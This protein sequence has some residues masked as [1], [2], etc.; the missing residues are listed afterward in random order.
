VCC[1]YSFA[2]NWGMI[3]L[4]GDPGGKRGSD[5][6]VEELRQVPCLTARWPTAQGVD[7]TPLTVRHAFAEA[8]SVMR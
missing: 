4:C 7:C 6:H 5:R 1:K 8:N 2:T 3:S